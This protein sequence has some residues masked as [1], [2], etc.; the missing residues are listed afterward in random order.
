MTVN[1][2]IQIG[3]VLKKNVDQSLCDLCSDSGVVLKEFVGLSGSQLSMKRV[4]D[5]ER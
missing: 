1:F 2:V 5:C 4:N 3:F